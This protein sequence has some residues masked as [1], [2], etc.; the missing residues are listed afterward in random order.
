MKKLFVLFLFIVLGTTVYA[1]RSVTDNG[2][3]FRYSSNYNFYCEEGVLFTKHPDSGSS[4]SGDC[5]TLIKYPQSKQSTSYTI[6]G[7][8]RVIAKGAFQGNKYIKTIRLPS[9]V[10]YIGDNA[11]E[12]C[13]QLTSIEIYQSTNSVI[14]VEADDSPSEARE[15]GRY[16]I[17]GVKIQEGEDGK[18]QIILYSDGT[19]KK[20]AE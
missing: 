7:W 3:I 14:A 2:Y 19:A 11:F 20:V 8:V 13:D 4:W 6:P 17:Q 9:T 18:I 12:G 5:C 10:Y 16:N 1:Q 15:V